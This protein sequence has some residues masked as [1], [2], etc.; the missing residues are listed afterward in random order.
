MEI[1]KGS[2]NP[3]IQ[4]LCAK[5]SRANHSNYKIHHFGSKVWGC[6]GWNKQ[7]YKAI[8]SYLL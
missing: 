2:F 6:F 3:A 1:D 4:K 8:Y 5:A 7:A